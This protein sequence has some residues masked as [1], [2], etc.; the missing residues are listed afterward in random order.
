MPWQRSY[1]AV[2]TALSSIIKVAE[3]TRTCIVCG[4]QFIDTPLGSPAKYCD[5]CRPYKLTA[6]C[7]WCGRVYDDRRG[8]SNGICKWCAPREKKYRTGLRIIA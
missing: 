6:V 8:K 7:S 3:R 4:A 5:I 1:I 2:Q